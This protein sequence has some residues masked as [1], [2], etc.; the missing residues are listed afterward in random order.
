MEVTMNPFKKQTGILTTKEL[1]LE[2]DKQRVINE[3]DLNKK[4]IERIIIYIEKSNSSKDE[5]FAAGYR[6]SREVAGALEFA[7]N[8][9]INDEL[10]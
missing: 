8:K 6:N 5:I 1:L 4:D 2:N 9:I 3:L 7:K 10:S